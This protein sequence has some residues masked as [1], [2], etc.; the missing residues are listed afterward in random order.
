MGRLGDP[1]RRETVL[2]QIWHLATV[3]T[4]VIEGPYMFCLCLSVLTVI[5]A[6][7]WNGR[8]LPP[9]P[10]ASSVHFLDAQF[11]RLGSLRTTFSG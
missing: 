8:S 7:T 10:V 3:S 5:S 6:L 9:S 2:P 4:V 11:V 1:Q